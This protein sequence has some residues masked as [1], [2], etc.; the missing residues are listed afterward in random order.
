MYSFDENLRLAE[1]TR[2]LPRLLRCEGASRLPV[3]SEVPPSPHNGF[4]RVEDLYITRNSVFVTCNKSDLL[5]NEIDF[6]YFCIVRLL[7]FF[8]LLFEKKKTTLPDDDNK[9]IVYQKINK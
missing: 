2:W 7:F 4:M 1:K 3:D 9:T 5:L 6:T 8:F